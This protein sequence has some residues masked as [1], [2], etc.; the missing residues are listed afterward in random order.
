MG[1][2]RLYTC[3]FIFD[4][5]TGNIIMG[6]LSAFGSFAMFVAM[7]VE[8]CTL[9]PYKEMAAEEEDYNAE[10][11]ITGLYAMSIILVLMFLFKLCTDIVFIY[12]VIMEKATIIRAYFVMW[13]VFF[14]LSMFTFFLNS[15]HYNAGTICIEVFYISLNVYAILLCNSFYKELNCREEVGADMNVL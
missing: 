12:G 7:I 14:L 8:A 4:L 3:C 6:S 15:P 1:L 5:K 10:A 11:E 9:E 2:P 13:I